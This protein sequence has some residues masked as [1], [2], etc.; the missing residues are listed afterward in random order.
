ME[1]IQIN[2]ILEILGRPAGNV[3][4][5]LKSLIVRL[6]GEKG[7]KI[8]S[9]TIHSPAPVKDSNDL[10]TAFA[11]LTLELDSL[12]NYFGII[13]AY[14]PANVEIISPEKII[15]DNQELNFL[16]NKILQRLHDYDAIAKKM[17]FD[18][19]FLLNKL[20]E[21]AP[22]LFKKLENEVMPKPLENSKPLKKAKSKVKKA[23]PKK[24]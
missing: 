7:V 1:K 8:L 17:I 21:A 6:T 2:M 18:R 22:Q 16:G 24:K 3:Q 11:E 19:D 14:M 23:K 13:F 4:E 15:L 20:K 5:G 12:S 10:F 9:Q